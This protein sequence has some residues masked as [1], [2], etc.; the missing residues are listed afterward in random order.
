MEFNLGIKD[1]DLE[2]LS[3][4]ELGELAEQGRRFIK[5]EEAKIIEALKPH[6]YLETVSYTHL[7]AH[8]T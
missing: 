4:E 6:I 5:A 2:G 8:E 7:R 3:D 1:S